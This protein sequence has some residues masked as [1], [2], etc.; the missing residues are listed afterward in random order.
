[1]KL[2]NLLICGFF[3]GFASSAVAAEQ[4][5]STGSVTQASKSENFDAAF[6]D[7][8]TKHHQDG[9]EMAK[10]AQDRAQSP[11]V[12]KLSQKIIKDQTKEIE[13]MQK[14]RQRHYSSVPKSES[15]MEKMDMSKLEN[16]KGVEFDKAFLDMMA[17][18]HEMGMALVER[19]TKEVKRNE[20][21]Q[22]ASNAMKNQ[23]KE[24]AQMH[25]M[26]GHGEGSSPTGSTNN[27]ETGH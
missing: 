20:I 12:K 6:L 2:R 24:V 13:Q 1:M 5:S 25:K 18:H 7:Q 23:K 21:K 11:E 26:M 19:A 4:S 14:W 16:S 9:I 27:H 3:I 22:F 17:K 10:L 15:K 8:F